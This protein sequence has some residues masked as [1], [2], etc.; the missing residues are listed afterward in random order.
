[1][2]NMMRH[3]EWVISNRFLQ[4]RL[5]ADDGV[6]RSVELLNKRT[7][8][9][10]V[11][12]GPEFVIGGQEGRYDS[13]VF[14]LNGPP[15]PI[16]NG[17]VFVLEPVLPCYY[18]TVEL[19]YTA[20][21][22]EPVIRKTITLRHDRV[23]GAFALEEVVVEQ[24]AL[25]GSTPDFAVEWGQPVFAGEWFLG[26]EHPAFWTQQTGNQV[27]LSVAPAIVLAQGQRL[28]L[29][30]AVLG[31]ADAGN[32]LPDFWRYL[33]GVRAQPARVFTLMN[34]WYHAPFVTAPICHEALRVLD[35]KLLK[36]HP[37]TL[38]AFVIDDGWDDHER[39]WHVNRERFPE[40]L[41]PFSDAVRQAGLRLG[42]WCSPWGG[43][44][45]ARNERARA[46]ARAGFGTVKNAQGQSEQLCLGEEAYFRYYLNRLINLVTSSDVSFFKFDGF[47]YVCNEPDHGHPVGRGSVTWNA[48]RMIEI[49]GTLRR[50]RPDIFLLGT[51]GFWNSPWWLMHLDS[52]FIGGG[53]DG[54]M[55]AGSPRQ[56][57]LTYRDSV[58]RHR[59]VNMRSRFP[60]GNSGIHGII[61]ARSTA[62]YYANP[63]LA[64]ADESPA[65]W[66]SLVWANVGR[67][68]GMVE[69]YLSPEI[70]TDA[71]YARLGEG[72]SIL[73]RHWEVLR[74]GRWL[75]GDPAQ[76]EAYGILHDG[77]S[78]G[79]LLFVRNPSTAPARLRLPAGHW[80]PGPGLA[81][82]PRSKS[83]VL[84][85]FVSG[86]LT[87][88]R[89][90]TSKGKNTKLR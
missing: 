51:I 55:G 53:D 36:P 40:G 63:A 42:L 11:L 17:L 28:T 62:P 46:G 13:T 56:R 57:D 82:G 76:G 18:L 30:A 70:L 77:T 6:L 83:L 72:I 26:V 64:F 52:L 68:V 27:G 47:L 84:P 43:Y 79:R 75:G 14:R 44:E 59:L 35:E 54:G 71:Q 22:D 50:Y 69:M 19:A 87:S 34:T 49:A 3:G 29:P 21:S 86:L 41:L 73:R 10:T 25:A 85:P 45:H 39:L 48:N 37:G 90:T 38:D 32:P 20:K 7:R 2:K 24:L 31:V 4:R 74:H 80:A 12:S 88:C 78:K 81:G 58:I 66:E 9:R 8:R 16:A 67:G 5:V 23:P 15:R 60:L 65:D 89:T 1:M 61:K 33:D